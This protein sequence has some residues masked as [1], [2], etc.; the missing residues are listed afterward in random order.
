MNDGGYDAGHD[1]GYRRGYEDAMEQAKRN[2]DDLVA[3]LSE[4]RLQLIAELGRDIRAEAV[5]KDA[6]LREAKTL[7]ASQRA[8]LDAIALAVGY[9]E[10]PEGQDHVHR[11]SGEYIAARFRERDAEIERLEEQVE[12][13]TGALR[14]TL[15]C[16]E[17]NEE[18]PD[19]VA[20]EIVRAA[21][22]A[23]PPQPPKVGCTHARKLSEHCPVCPRGT[24]GAEAIPAQPPKVEHPY[25]SKC[26]ACSFEAEWGNEDV[27]HP[28]DPRA[29]SCL[30]SATQP[31]VA[32]G[33]AEG[34]CFERCPYEGKFDATPV[35]CQRE[36]GHPV[37]DSIGHQSGHIFW[38]DPP[39]APSPRVEPPPMRLVPVLPVD[40]EADARFDQELRN[41]AAWSSKPPQEVCEWA[42]AAY[43]ATH[44]CDHCP[45]AATPRVEPEPPKW[46]SCEHGSWPDCGCSDK[47]PRSKP[48]EPKPCPDGMWCSCKPGTHEGGL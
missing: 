23:E 28:V 26:A 44:L 1:D 25:E 47:F 39:A 30:K 2:Y 37:D 3:E 40:E 32:A 15:D 12:A 20:M 33:Q 8:E 5:T 7:L 34:R 21:L 29:H 22:A 41:R 38:R 43:P 10:R 19:T 13:L 9:G 48:P 6:E 46:T 18:D 35:L 24:F 4:L 16:L 31:P 17:Q 45:S 11:A 27:P 42:R 36:R 14:E